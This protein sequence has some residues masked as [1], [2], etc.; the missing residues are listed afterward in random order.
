MSENRPLA[1]P[2]VRVW[3]LPVR[4]FHWLLVAVIAVA[5]LSSDEDGALAPWH[6]AVGW[7][8]AVLI[9][10]RIVWGFVG[11]EH[12]R[13]V[14]FLRPSRLADHLKGLAIGRPAPEL[15]HNPLG[16]LAVVGILA[17]VAA[18]VATGVAMLAGGE[19]APHEVLAY[20]LLA[21]VGVHVAAVVIMSIASRE[22]LVRAMVTG[23]KPAAKHPDG[24]DA[25]PPHV[26]AYGVAVVTLVSAAIAAT[27]IDPNA[28]GPHSRA[29]A[30][31][32]RGGA[33]PGA[34]EREA[35]R[36]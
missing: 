21:L 35:E 3:D 11:G 15:G 7:I 22:N 29:E 25:R 1:R 36:D 19:D 16:G 8:A 28:F 26:L 9:V 4:L 30:G 13:F 12:A 33:Q 2:D 24:H 32:V 20:A 14:D 6:Q 31:E 23:A 18:T 27:R 5:F 10:F 34:G 17:L